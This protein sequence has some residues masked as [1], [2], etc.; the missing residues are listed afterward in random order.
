ML[1]RVRVPVFKTDQIEV[2][3]FVSHVGNPRRAKTQID[4]N[5]AD[6]SNINVY[7]QLT[8]T[9]CVKRGRGPHSWRTVM[10]F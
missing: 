4:S 2:I 10:V 5:R 9:C 8:V 6:A 7:L 3:A 1:T